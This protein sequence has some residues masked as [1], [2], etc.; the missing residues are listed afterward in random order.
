MVRNFVY[1]KYLALF[2]CL[3]PI[4]DTD[5]VFADF[6]FDVRQVGADVSVTGS[7]SM[8]L[9]G[10]I[11]GFNGVDGSRIIPSLPLVVVGP[12]GSNS[13]DVFFADTFDSPFDFGIGDEIVAD[14]GM[15]DLFGVDF[16]GIGLPPGYISNSILFGSSVYNDQTFDTLGITPGTYVWTFET[17]NITNTITLNAN[18]IPE[19]VSIFVLGFLSAAVLSRRRR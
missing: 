11:F 12:T 1:T 17:N 14:F 16:S 6:V 9:D 10:L 13:I 5:P 3:F 7:G 8:D 18:V 15:G 19:P 4:L 2:A